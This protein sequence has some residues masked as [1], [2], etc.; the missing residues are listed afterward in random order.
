LEFFLVAFLILYTFLAIAS[1]INCIV[2]GDNHKSYVLEIL[3]ERETPELFFCDTLRNITHKV[4]F[5]DI[6]TIV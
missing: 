4:Y 2:S 3:T 1:E 5:I 6:M